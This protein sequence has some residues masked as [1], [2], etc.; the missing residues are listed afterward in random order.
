MTTVTCRDTE[1]A[2]YASTARFMLDQLAILYRRLN[3]LLHTS[4]RTSWPSCT[5]ASMPS[6]SS[7]LPPPT[8]L[9]ERPAPMNP[10]VATL[11]ANH[12]GQGRGCSS[13]AASAK[14]VSHPLQN[15]SGTHL[16]EKKRPLTRP[17]PSSLS[18]ENAKEAGEKGGG[19]AAVSTPASAAP[20]QTLRSTTETNPD[21][22][23]LQNPWSARAMRQPSFAHA[24]ASLVP[25]AVHN[26]RHGPS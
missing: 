26:A 4:R 19:C 16:K 25:A 17:L 3:D 23:H 24:R 21:V 15:K 6:P 20:R 2:V 13:L 5:D 14:Q 8:Q 11:P 18:R 1:N 7:L 10:Y 9:L 12:P 22:V